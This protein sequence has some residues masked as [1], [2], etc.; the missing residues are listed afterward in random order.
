[1]PGFLRLALRQRLVRFITVGVGAAALLLVL[2]YLFI[3]IGLPPFAAGLAGY[4]GAFLAAY[5]AQRC[6]TFG[7]AHGHGHALPRYFVLQAGCALTSGGL[8]HIA[9]DGLGMAPLTTSV[10]I[11]VATSAVSYI[12]SSRWVFPNEAA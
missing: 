11:T 2:A 8:A 9:V 12:V 1:M 7:A 3:S 10:L 5:T 4:G 6:W